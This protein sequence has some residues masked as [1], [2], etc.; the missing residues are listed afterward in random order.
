MIFEDLKK[1]LSD[2]EI[3]GV[4][5]TDHNCYIKMSELNNLLKHS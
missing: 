2:M 3:I 5:F 1:A 4:D